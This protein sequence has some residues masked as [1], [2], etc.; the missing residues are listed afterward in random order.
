MLVHQDEATTAYEDSRSLASDKFETLPMMPPDEVI[1]DPMFEPHKCT[2][3]ELLHR[4]AGCERV[5]RREK[6]N[7]A[8]RTR[9]YEHQAMTFE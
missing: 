6:T 1:G 9:V 4:A 5:D 7:K 3:F 2:E 8:R